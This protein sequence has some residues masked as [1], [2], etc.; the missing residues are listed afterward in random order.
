MPVL[1]L[2]LLFLY[3]YPELLCPLSHS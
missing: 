2:P 3:P 1:F